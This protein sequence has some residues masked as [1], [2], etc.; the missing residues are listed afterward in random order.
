[1]HPYVC[2]YCVIYLVWETAC[3][4]VS[5]RRAEKTCVPRRRRRWWSTEKTHSRNDFIGDGRGQALWAN[6]WR[7]AC[8]CATFGG[9]HGWSDCDDDGEHL[10]SCRTDDC[11]G[12]CA[13]WTAR[14]TPGERFI[15][16]QRSSTP[17]TPC[18]FT[19]CTGTTLH[20][21]YFVRPRGSTD[22]ITTN[23]PRRT[24]LNNGRLR[25]ADVFS[26]GGGRHFRYFPTGNLRMRDTQKLRSL[27]FLSFLL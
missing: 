2:T 17:Q 14:P 27:I 5:Q 3:E 18:S 25:I 23:L 9:R 12:T 15:S 19:C 20:G 4:A 21:S 13:R 24:P 16:L 7:T 11:S 22:W 6:G 26:W 1:M 8:A 10:W